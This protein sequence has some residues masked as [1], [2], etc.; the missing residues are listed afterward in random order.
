M[1]PNEREPL[2]PEE[3]DGEGVVALPDK[4]VVSILDLA[5]DIDLAIDGAAP[6]DLA[7]ALNANVVAPIDAA[8]SAN[9]LSDGSTAQAMSAQSVQLSQLIEADANATAI[10]DST[11]DQSDTVVG[12]A[13]PAGAGEAPML[14]GATEALADGAAA[15][16][17]A[18]VDGSI[19]VDSAGTIIGTLDAA[20]G[21][22][23]SA[24]G[25]ILGTLNETTGVVVDSAGNLIGTVTDLVDGATVVGS[26]GQ[27][28][29]VLDAATG[30]VLDATGNVVGAV[31]PLTGQVLDTVGNVLGTVTDFLDGTTVLDSAGNVIGILDGAT[32][33]VVNS[34]GQVVGALNPVTGQV[35]DAA[36]NLLGTVGQVVDDVTDTLAGLNTGDLLK[37]DLLNVDVN[38]D[39][40]ADLAAPIN[41][42][43]AANANIAAPIDASVAANILSE[44]SQAT[45]IA[46]QDVII[47]QSI[48]GNANAM[49]DQ[50]SNIDQSSLEPVD[51]DT[52]SADD[53]AAMQVP[54]D[55]GTAATGEPAAT[56]QPVDAGTAPTDEPAATEQPAADAQTAP[57]AD[58]STS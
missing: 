27:V 43:V 2:T 31:N 55:A 15:A 4:E 33:N 52:A 8:V 30:N 19:V 38:V 46:Q 22:V 24:D 23:V 41:G 1:D 20:T 56:E 42:A 10:Q 51:T 16:A 29:G 35:L 36:G 32:G 40:D 5:A 54:V 13:V 34:L 12:G 45:A 9:L 37:G 48:T 57:Q 7:V 25:S 49:S 14:M 53:S 17:A 39:L 18:P 6:I 11:I 47:S 50:V 28:L 44:N 3:L 58:D 26:S 21:N